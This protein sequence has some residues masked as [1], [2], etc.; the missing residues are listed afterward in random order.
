MQLQAT[1]VIQLDIFKETSREFMTKLGVFNE[2]LGTFPAVF[3]VITPGVF[4][5]DLETSP[6]VFLATKPDI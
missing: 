4:Q 2:N 5:Q 6:F 3:V 1:S